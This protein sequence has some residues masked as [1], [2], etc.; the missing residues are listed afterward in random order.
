MDKDRIFLCYAGVT[1]LIIMLIL[2]AFTL[3]DINEEIEL[4]DISKNIRSSYAILQ[5]KKDMG[6][7]VNMEF[8]MDQKKVKLFLDENMNIATCGDQI[9][10][11]TH[12]AMKNPFTLEVIEYP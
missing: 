1:G 9:V 6:C 7:F 2:R 8:E 3:N 4:R 10:R 5:E 11:F 12:Y